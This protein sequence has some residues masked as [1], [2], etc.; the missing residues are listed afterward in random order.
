MKF[1]KPVSLVKLLILNKPRV[2]D[3]LNYDVLLLAD[4][5]DVF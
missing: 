5:A 4:C 2:M 3:V 1:E